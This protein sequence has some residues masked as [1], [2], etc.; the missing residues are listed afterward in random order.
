MCVSSRTSIDSSFSF[1]E[2]KVSDT[3]LSKNIWLKIVIEGHYMLLQRKEWCIIDK[4]WWKKSINTCVRR[5]LSIEIYISKTI[6]EIN[7]IVPIVFISYNQNHEYDCFP[8]ESIT[9]IAK[10]V[11]SILDHDQATTGVNP[12]VIEQ[13]TIWIKRIL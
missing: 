10:N 8:T 12:R 5:S 9:T 2:S 3:E 13:I 7:W 1:V 11:I 4:K 6:F